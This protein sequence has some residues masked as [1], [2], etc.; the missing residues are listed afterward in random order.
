MRVA[1]IGC[2]HGDQ[3]RM[4]TEQSNVDLI[5]C[6]GDFQALRNSHDLSAMCSPE[7]HRKL[8]TFHE[9][10]KDDRKVPL[11]IVIGGNHE[12]SAYMAE[13]FYGGWLAPNIYYLGAGGSVIVN[14]LRIAGASGIYSRPDL[15]NKGHYERAPLSESDA[16]SIYHLRSYTE[17]RLSLLP[18]VDIF[19]SHDWPVDI[20]EFGDQADL[21]RVMPRFTRDVTAGC[22]GAPALSRV[23]VATAPRYWFAAHMHVKF[24]AVRQYP[25]TKRTPD[26]DYDPAPQHWLRDHALSP[27]RTVEVPEHSGCATRFLALSKPHPK[28]N[29]WFEVLDIPFP[30]ET[31]PP[32]LSFD[33]EWLA[34]CKATH[35]LPQGQHASPLPKDIRVK[36]AAARVGLDEKASGPVSN[37]QTFAKTAPGEGEGTPEPHYANTQT[38]AFCAMLGIEDVTNPKAVAKGVGKGRGKVRKNGR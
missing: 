25:P 14:G 7:R 36:V 11:T 4:F 29:D 31:T 2:L 27:S 37:V 24:P 13:L 34:I 32:K 6:C 23:M 3:H 30:D 9:Y 18:P 12:S 26:H 28:K 33:P 5:L 20:T 22:F 10:Y 17:E 38:T 21:L 8:G 35:P 19:L 1:V 16:R 15:F